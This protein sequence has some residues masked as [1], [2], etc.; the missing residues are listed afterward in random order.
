MPDFPIQLQIDKYT[1]AST[2]KS[3]EPDHKKMAS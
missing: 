3:R 2:V 1:E